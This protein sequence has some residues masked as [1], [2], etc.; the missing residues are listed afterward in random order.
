MNSITS[1]YIPRMSAFYTEEAVINIM[2]NLRVG[3]VK[4]VDFIPINKKPGFVE[5]VDD[6]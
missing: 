4:R 1:I 5:K 3:I 6:V 2:F